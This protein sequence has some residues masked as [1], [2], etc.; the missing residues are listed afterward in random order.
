M[1]KYIFLDF[2][3]T[4]IDDVD[5]CLDLL[6]QILR[7]QHKKEITKE[8]YKDIFTFPV[9]K[10]YEL[11]GVD[12]SIESFE[13][14]ADKFI[15]SYQPLSL[16]CDLYPK[17]IE[18]FKKLKE[19]GYHLI[20]LSASEKNNL[21]EQCESFGIVPY[22]DAILGIDNIHAESKIGIA[23]NYMKEQKI[24]GE[25]ILFV[26]DT[27]HDLEVAKAMGANCM[28]V[29]S[30]H[31]SRKVLEQGGVPIVS[32]VYALLDVLEKAK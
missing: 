24:K 2:N 10:Y 32:N 29:S 18:A 23:L 27:L 5:L 1:M 17:S 22:F 7:N 6:N 19:K 4:I 14:L 12:F 13:S 3:G 8:Q 25:D 20:I 9:K 30:G 31:Q 28:L 11:A 15:A 26:G 21:L 16:K